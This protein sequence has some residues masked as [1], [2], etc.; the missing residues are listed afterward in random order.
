MANTSTGS[1]KGDPWHCQFCTDIFEGG[2][3]AFSVYRERRGRF[4]SEPYHRVVGKAEKRG[5]SVEVG[6]K[7]KPKP[8]G[9]DSTFS[10]SLSPPSAA[11][12]L[13]SVS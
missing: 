7:K 6:G 9:L 13:C 3:K 4:W 1:L 12:W 10:L 5:R 2:K 8:T 11:V